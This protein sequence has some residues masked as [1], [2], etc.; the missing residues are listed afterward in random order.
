MTTESHKA[1]MAYLQWASGLLIMY[2]TRSFLKPDL[3]RYNFHAVK[4]TFLNVQIEFWQLNID[5]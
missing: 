2:F 3:V 1:E 4:F 5:V